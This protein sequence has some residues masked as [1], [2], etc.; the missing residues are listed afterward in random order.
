MARRNEHQRHSFPGWSHAGIISKNWLS[1]NW[2]SIGIYR[3]TSINEHGPLPLGP[4]VC[5]PFFGPFLWAPGATKRASLGRDI[6]GGMVRDPSRKVVCLPTTPYRYVIMQNRNI[7]KPSTKT[8]SA[9]YG[10]VILRICKNC[11]DLGLGGED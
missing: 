2:K 7:E 9:K 10:L 5:F 11:Y 4:F 3:W 1:K 6:S 8:K